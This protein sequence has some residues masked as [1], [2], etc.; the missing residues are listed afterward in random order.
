MEL[1]TGGAKVAV[2]LTESGVVDLDGIHP[3]SIALEDRTQNPPLR[4]GRDPKL[5]AFTDARWPL[6]SNRAYT[7]ICREEGTQVDASALESELATLK[8]EIVGL[9]EKITQW[10][11]RKRIKDKKRKR[12]ASR[13]KEKGGSSKTRTPE[14]EREEVE[15]LLTAAAREKEDEREKL[16]DEGMRYRRIHREEFAPLS[17]SK[18]E[19]RGSSPRG[20]FSLIAR[21]QEEEEEE[22]GTRDFFEEKG[23]EVME[24][25][26]GGQ[27]FITLR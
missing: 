11:E 18:D 1:P 6:V 13:T 3:L 7:L 26:V 14:P 19:L 24:I 20:K 17:R 2:G 4:I 8:K 12:K 23:S 15:R 10:E 25:N 5:R 21:A 9:N 16:R 27:Y 22:E